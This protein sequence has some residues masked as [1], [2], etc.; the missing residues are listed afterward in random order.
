SELRAQL[1]GAW[2]EMAGAHTAVQT[3]RRDALPATEEA[4]RVVRQAYEQGQIPL[5]DVLDAQR[6]LIS[7]RREIIEAESNFVAAHARA[8]G[9]VDATFPA[10]A[11]LL[12]SP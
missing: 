7:L 6:A 8:E 3:L 12:L 5:I 4:H 11:A 10:T 9:L 2:Q 1:S